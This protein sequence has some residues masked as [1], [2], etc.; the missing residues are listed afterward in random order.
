MSHDDEGYRDTKGKY[1]KGI[2]ELSSKKVTRPDE[3]LKCL[4]TNKCS[5]GNRQEEL[6]AIVLVKIHSIVAISETWWDDSND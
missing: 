5:L 6:E 2:K 4:Y 1:F 3:Q